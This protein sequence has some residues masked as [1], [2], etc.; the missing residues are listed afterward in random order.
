MRRNTSGQVVTAML[1]TTSAAATACVPSTSFSITNATGT[2]TITVTTSGS[3]GYLSGNRIN[4]T[5]VVGSIAQYV[6]GIHTL[7]S[8]S[9]TT[10]TFVPYATASGSWT[11]G[12]ATSLGK[13]EVWVSKEGAT[14]VIGTGAITHIGLDDSG[15]TYTPIASPTAVGRGT[16]GLWKYQPTAGE[17]NASNVSF[18]FV[19]PVLNS[20][21]VTQNYEPTSGPIMLQTVVTSVTSQTV[22]VLQSGSSEDND[23]S[24]C[25]VVFEDHTDATTVGKKGVAVISG[26]TGSTLTATLTEATVGYTVASSNLVTILS[27]TSLR[28]A[29]R[30]RRAT[31]DASGL[32]SL[33]ATGLDA[34]T[35]AN[36]SGVADTFPKM[37]VQ[38]WRRFFKKAT[39]TSTQIKTYAD[40]DTTVVTTQTVS[41]DGTTQTQGSAS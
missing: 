30:N 15:A 36:P 32:V 34:I 40:N 8:A 22:L 18:T 6:N 1:T 12:G 38:L 27:D 21:R 24:G 37:L 4:I 5:G 13:V 31:V 10:M 16:L 29:T 41:D 28:P 2:T 17:T 35:V 11:S 33:A 7:V 39:K 26:Y 3:H 9:G 14:P 19:A 25:T 20:L 23:Y